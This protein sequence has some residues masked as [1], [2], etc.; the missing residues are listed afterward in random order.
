[1]NASLGEG[2]GKFIDDA[3][4]FRPE[5]KTAGLELVRKD[6][7]GSALPRFL[8]GFFSSLSS[9]GGLNA[10]LKSARTFLQMADI[11]MVDRRRGSKR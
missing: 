6:A 3:C 9:F 1:M 11:K 7:I 2:E 5:R 8:V 10:N 4:L